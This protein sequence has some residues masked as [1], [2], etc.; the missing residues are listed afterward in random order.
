VKVFGNRGL[1]ITGLLG[2]AIAAPAIVL[3]V[4]DDPKEPAPTVSAATTDIEE[5]QRLGQTIVLAFEEPHFDATMGVDVLYKVSVT[6]T[7]SSCVGVTVT[8]QALDAT[9]EVIIEV[10]GKIGSDG[11]ASSFDPIEAALVDDVAM[12]FEL[13][14]DSIDV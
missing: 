4:T 7:D 11:F 9:D 2:L 6:E 5:C 1:I 14:N 13:K 10:S 12:T 8:V 3:A